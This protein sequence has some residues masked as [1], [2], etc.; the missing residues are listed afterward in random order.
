MIFEFCPLAFVLVWESRMAAS[1]MLPRAITATSSS[2]LVVCVRV[3]GARALFARS[4]PNGYSLYPHVSSSTPGCCFQG[5]GLRGLC[6]C[7]HDRWELAAAFASYSI[8]CSGGSWVIVYTS[9]SRKRLSGL[10]LAPLLLDM[11]QSPGRTRMGVASL[12]ACSRTAEV[13]ASGPDPLCTL[14]TAAQDTP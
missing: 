6:S 9:G 1:R 4:P 7:V 2:R 8:A 10:S 11:W 5:Q 13:V 14:R 12:V 3:D